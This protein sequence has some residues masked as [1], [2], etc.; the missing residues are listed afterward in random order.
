[1]ARRPVN[2]P[3][4]ITTEFG[5]SDPNALFKRHSGVDYAVPTGTNVYAPV[6]G[7]VR[8]ASFHPVRGN[9]VGIYDGKNTHRL[10][11]NSVFKT[12][13][14]R[15]VNEGDV[16]ALSGTTGLSTGPHVHWDIISGDRMDATGFGDFIS[17]ATVLANPSPPPPPAALQPYQRRVGSAGVNYRDAPHTKAAIRQEFPP[18][19]IMDFGG[20]IKGE[21]V[22]GNDVW[23]VGRYTGGFSWSGSFDDTGT[24]DLVNLTPTPPPPTPPSYSVRPTSGLWGID[25]SNHQ[26]NVDYEAIKLTVDFAILKAGHTGP[27]HGGGPNNRDGKFDTFA[28]GLKNLPLGFYWYC[29]FDEDPLQEAR[30]FATVVGSREGSLWMDLEEPSGNSQ[31]AMKFIHEVESL[32]GRPCHIYTYH[33]YAIS[34]PWVTELLSPHRKVWL[35]HYDRRPG[36]IL[37]DTPLGSPVMHQ[38]TSK[39]SLPG[40]N[41]NVDLNIFYGTREDFM[42]LALPFEEAPTPPPG[43]VVNPEIETRIRELED[44]KEVVLRW[45]PFLK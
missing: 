32:M 36:D 26:G 6:S 33:N 11:H 24:H 27:S 29:Y 40:I 16:V 42:N 21:S 18:G 38:Y 4:T 23:F 43:T 5:V 30:N 17:P 15:R 31:W 7:E 1:M 13:V 39:G 35:A 37:N 22:Q 12:S 45:F 44:F 41:G 8:Y 14:G 10:M 9:M 3:Y 20:F 34:H 2:A 28:D 25:I 19:D